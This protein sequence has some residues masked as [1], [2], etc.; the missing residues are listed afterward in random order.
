MQFKDIKIYSYVCLRFSTNLKYQNISYY[1]PRNLLY[2][3][4]QKYCLRMGS[5]KLLETLYRLNETSVSKLAAQFR[6]VFGF[7]N[8]ITLNLTPQHS[9]LIII[10]LNKFIRRVGYLF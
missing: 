6:N 2:T 5:Q 7:S 3:G 1:R 4:V 8:K 10:Y 9:E